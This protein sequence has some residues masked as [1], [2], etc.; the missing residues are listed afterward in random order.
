[1]SLSIIIGPMFSGKTW[2]LIKTFNRL[3]NEES[4]KVA[5]INYSADTRYGENVLS[6]HNQIKIP[7][8]MTTR[9]CDIWLDR[10]HPNWFE[11]RQSDAILINE[12]QFFDDLKDVVLDMVE[13]HGKIVE[14]CGLDGTYT[15]APFSDG[16]I[17]KL[18]PYADHIEKLNGQCS[19]CA[20]KSIFTHRITRE[21]GE[22]I[23]GGSDKYIP[24]CR[25]CYQTLNSCDL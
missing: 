6:T 14:I 8:L 21:D 25:K 22:V 1:M 11:L 2:H 9:L 17:F 3:C 10:E 24:V 4:K 19:K 12:A 15:R 16:D 13:N 7:C 23:I 18:M 5:V 20:N